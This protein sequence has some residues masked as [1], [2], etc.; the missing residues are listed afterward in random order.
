MKRVFV[1]EPIHADAMKLLAN[2]VEI[3]MGSNQD[4]LLQQAGDCDGILIRSHKVPG[5]FLANAPKVKVVGKHGIGVDNIDV[6]AATAR[7]ILVVNAPESNIHS[8]AEHALGMILASAKNFLQGDAML[9]SSGFKH[10]NA[11]VGTE[12][13]GKTIGIIGLGKIGLQLARKLQCLDVKIIAFD[14]YAKPQLAK[15]LDIGLVSNIDL[16]F[17]ESDFI[18]LHVPLTNTTRGMVGK[19]DFVKMKKSAYLINVSRGEIVRENDLYEAL[20]NKQIRGAALDVF[21]KEPPAPDNP[22]FMLDNVLLSPHNAALTEDAL[23]A[24]AT[25]SAQGILDCLNGKIPKYVVNPQVL[26]SNSLKVS[27]F[28]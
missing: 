7:G 14:P 27:F 26:N 4:T 16:V 19:D 28:N 21:E 13:K 11:I 12:L 20:K 10:R 15:E 1:S 23:I 6:D 8:V 22:L 2:E 5:D 18:S 3:V 24:M 25:Q 9:R 17:A